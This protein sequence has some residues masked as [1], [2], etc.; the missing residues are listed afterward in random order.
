MIADRLR[1]IVQ[2]ICGDPDVADPFS[3]DMGQSMPR[4]WRKPRQSAA[5]A[6]VER[7]PV[8]AHYS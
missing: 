8:A 2:H 7:P 6:A 1:L 4:R 5:L 3:D